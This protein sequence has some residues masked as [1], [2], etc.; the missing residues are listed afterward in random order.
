MPQPRGLGRVDLIARG[1]VNREDFLHDS[2]LL[3]ADNRAITAHILQQALK[4]RVG[5]RCVWVVAIVVTELLA[6][7]GFT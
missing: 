5:D 7:I 2:V 1:A 6:Q 3:V 4:G